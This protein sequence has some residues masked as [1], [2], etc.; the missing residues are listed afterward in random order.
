[1][2]GSLSK[3]FAQEQLRIRLEEA[4]GEHQRQ[5]EIRLIIGDLVKVRAEMQQETPNVALPGSTW[6]MT[7]AGENS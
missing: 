3:P 4:L 1:V 7:C 2:R 6:S 5:V